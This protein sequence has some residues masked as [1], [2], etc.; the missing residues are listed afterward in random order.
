MMRVGALLSLS[1][2]AAAQSPPPPTFDILANNLG[3]DLTTL[4]PGTTLTENTVTTSYGPIVGRD[5][6]DGLTR[7]YGIPTSNSTAAAAPR[8]KMP[9]ALTP[10]TTPLQTTLIQH[11]YATE[12]CLKVNLAT[13]TSQIGSSSL[14]PTFVYFSG[15]GYIRE[16]NPAGVQ[17]GMAFHA[18]SGITGPD[19]PY[20]KAVLLFAHYRIGPL[21]YLAHPGMPANGNGNWGIADGIAALQWIRDNI[22]AFGGDPGRVTTQGSSAGG[23][24]QMMLLASP[25]ST[26]LVH[27]IIAMSPYSSYEPAF[28]SLKASQEMNMMYAYAFCG[29]SFAVPAVGSADASSQAACLSAA[30]FFAGNFGTHSMNDAAYFSSANLNSSATDVVSAFETYYNAPGIFNT[31]INYLPW[32]SYPNVDGYVLDMDPWSSYRMGRNKDMTLLIGHAANEYSIIFDSPGDIATTSI[33][34]HQFI[35]GLKTQLVTAGIMDV[36]NAAHA[37]PTVADVTSAVYGDFVNSDFTGWT[38]NIQSATDIWFLR[39]I[40]ESVKALMMGGSTKIYKVLHVF[41]VPA[42]AAALLGSFGN[43]MGAYHAGEDT[44]NMGHYAFGVDTIGLAFGEYA[45]G[46]IPWLPAE[47]QMGEA[48]VYYWKNTFMTGNPNGRDDKYPAWGANMDET[49]VFSPAYGVGAGLGGCIRIHPCVSES[50]AAYRKTQLAYFNNIGQYDATMTCAA[51][52][53]PYVDFG[54]SGSVT[55]T[56]GLSMAGYPY[57]ALNASIPSIYSCSTCSCAVSRRNTLFGAATMRPTCSC[58]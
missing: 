16:D 31:M 52:S 24:Y 33:A 20:G 38:T 44:A 25:L 8:F 14:I 57:P 23:A 53:A 12:D 21:G 50:A 27:N 37:A 55:G 40:T 58:A 6:P 7:F 46:G 18:R 22:R 17:M 56:F 42:P 5:C 11:C 49:M 15:G 39:G 4:F 45:Y 1:S 19:D 47:V 29:S 41:G 36:W 28:F 51:G 48:M 13:P 43:L 30:D 26:G 35:L 54:A 32:T 2:I 9:I 3:D 10:W 34:N